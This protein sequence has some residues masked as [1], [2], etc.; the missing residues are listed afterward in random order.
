[1]NGYLDFIEFLIKA[2]E[3]D[4]VL[5]N[6]HLNSLWTQFII[7][8]NCIEESN[9]LF[10]HL[11]KHKSIGK[12]AFLILNEDNVEYLLTGC[13]LKAERFNIKTMN[14]ISYTCFESLVIEYNIKYG[15]LEQED[16]KLVTVKPN[17]IGMTQLWNIAFES[18]DIDVL[19]LINHFL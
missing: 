7:F 8:A 4:I 17:V 13:F 10:L 11:M 9:C 19:P 18:P 1:M 15:N 16:T 3:Y 12:T 5:T 6:E 2:S 14:N